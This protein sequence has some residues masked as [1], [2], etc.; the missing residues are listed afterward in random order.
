MPAG[1][2]Q[3]VSERLQRWR[4]AQRKA[5]GITEIENI[6]NMSEEQISAVKRR[7]K[8]GTGKGQR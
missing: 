5:L 3:D 2:E 6:P 1:Y 7:H 8:P 4:E